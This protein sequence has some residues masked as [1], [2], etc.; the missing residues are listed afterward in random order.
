MMIDQNTYVEI[1]RILLPVE[2]RSKN[3]PV[4]TKRIPFEM[5]LRGKLL[6]AASIGDFVEIETATKR[7]EK[8]IL[9][10]VNPFYSH[11]FGHYVPILTQIRDTILQETEDLL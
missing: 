10:A 6:K 3:L 7:I 11:N 5:R 8:G 1:Y 2:E 4:E 9:V